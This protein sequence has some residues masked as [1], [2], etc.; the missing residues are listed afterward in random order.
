MLAWERFFQE[1][2]ALLCPPSMVTAFP[3]RDTGSPL[4]LDGREENY[5]MVSA[6]TT[7]FNYTGLP[8]IVLPYTL[9]Q[10]GLPIGVQIVAKRWGESRLLAIAAALSE[11]TG[12]FQRPPGY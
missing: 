3:H 5:W 10:D 8:A 4:Q 6:H 12:G 11:V 1:W 2:D 7:I 9:D